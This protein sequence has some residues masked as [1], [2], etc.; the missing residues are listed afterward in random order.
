MGSS[1]IKNIGLSAGMSPCHRFR[2][3]R[4]CMSPGEDDNGKEEGEN[5]ENPG[6]FTVDG[7]KGALIAEENSRP[8]WE[9]FKRMGTGRKQKKR[10][11]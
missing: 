1:L 11:D 7:F 9:E 10:E 4:L 8:S 3:P 6:E 2:V 5:E